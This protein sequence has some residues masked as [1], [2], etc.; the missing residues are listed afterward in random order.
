MQIPNIIVPGYFASAIDY[1][2]LEMELNRLGMPT[3]T[4]PLKKSNWFPTLGGRSVVPIIKMLDRTVKET[5]ERYGTSEVNLIAHSAGGWISRIYM[6]EKPY[7]IHG[8]ATGEAATWKA[9]RYVNTLITLGTPHRSQE[10]WTKKNLNFVENNYAGA[11]HANVRYV[12][13]AGKAVYGKKRLGSWL[14]YQ[15]YLLTG[16]EGNTWGDGIVPIDCAHLEGATN[17]TLEGVWHSPKSPNIWYG[18]S[19]SLKAWIDYLHN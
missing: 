10:R 4:V 17:I 15:S 5:M 7:D 8:D 18:S 2:L 1:R 3:V 11:F 12:C 14:A 13:V 16:G 19:E 6:G 9:H